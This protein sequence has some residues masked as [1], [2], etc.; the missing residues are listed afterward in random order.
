MSAALRDMSLDWVT[1]SGDDHACDWNG[2]CPQEAVAV[3]IWR[4]SC[5]HM[6]PSTRVCAR[7]RDRILEAAGNVAKDFV[8]SECPALFWLDRM[9][10]VR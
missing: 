2:G 5:G 3:A 10:P 4:H 6:A 8:C 9:E 7:H 1:F